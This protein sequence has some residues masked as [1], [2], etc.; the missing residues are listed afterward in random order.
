MYF[1]IKSLYDQVNF[2]FKELF[3]TLFSEI[4]NIFNF[5]ASEPELIF[6]SDFLKDKKGEIIDVGSNKGAFSKQLERGL[7]NPKRFYCFEPMPYYVS[8]YKKLNFNYFNCALSD[9]S[10]EKSIYTLRLKIFK[11]FLKGFESFEKEN[12]TRYSKKMYELKT[13][14]VK[15][16]QLDSFNLEPCFIKIDVEGVEHKVIMG[17]EKTI[18]KYKP[19]IMLEINN[20]LKTKTDKEMIFTK[21]KHFRYEPFVY[22][23]NELKKINF[24]KYPFKGNSN[25]IFKFAKES[26]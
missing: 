17:A 21:L 7:G 1:K 9:T 6:L 16:K 14:T 23:N 11:T 19:L 20:N 15:V 4:L 8:Y 26:L 13:Y 22:V 25:V 18:S 10:G 3:T 24:E 5:N 12:V 2:P